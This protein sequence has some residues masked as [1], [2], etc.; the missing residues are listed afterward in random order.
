MAN[1]MEQMIEQAAAAIKEASL[2]SSVY[3]GCDS[4]RFKKHDA[5]T[6]RSQWYARYSTVIIL[7]MDSKH[8]CKLF[9]CMETEQDFGNLKQRILNE[10]YRAGAV[11]SAL[12][13]AI[14]EDHITGL[15][16]FQIHLD[17]NNSPNHKS[18]VAM[19]EAL[20][21]IRGL[22]FDAVIKPDAF[23]ATHAADHAVRSKPL[24]ASE[25][26]SWN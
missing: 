23:A 13:E 21:Y 19:K 17:L 7:H 16:C 8:G 10:C 14:G 1:T 12:V 11:G 18:N 2:D 9:H 6:G 3:V 4:I 5:D 22:G 26:P 24:K 25:C 20:G 15:N